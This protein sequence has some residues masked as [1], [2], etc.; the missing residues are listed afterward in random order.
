MDVLKELVQVLPPKKLQ[1]LQQLQT[2]SDEDS[3]V[4]R[5]YQ[6]IATGKIDTDEDARSFLQEISDSHFYK[7]KSELKG[8]LI[9]VLFLAELNEPGYVD[10]QKAY[11][12]VYKLW[13][14]IKLLLGKHAKKTAVQFARKLLT[15]AE[16]FEF[17]DLALDI[18]R[19]L[20]LHYGTIEGDEKKF[21]LYNDRFKYF[22]KL[23]HWEN[24]AEEYY[25]DLILQY[26]RS[27]KADEEV[28]DKAKGYLQELATGAADLDSYQL[29]LCR[30]LIRIMEYSGAND[31][32]KTIEAAKTLTDYFETKTYTAI[33][34][35]QIGYNQQLV[36]YILLK[37]FE[38]GK[39][40][41]DRGLS[42]ENRGGFNWFKFQEL[43]LLLALHAQEYGEAYQI[44][45]QTIKH[46]RFGRLPSATQEMWKIFEAY[47]AY[48]I[49]I[50]RVSGISDNALKNFR[51]GRFLNETPIFSRDKRGMNIPILVVQVLFFISRKDYSKA[52]DRIEA[53]KKYSS[54]YLRK[55]QSFRSN[56]FL[57][58][59]VEV[60]KANFHKAAVQRNT[61]DLLQKLAEVPVHTANQSYEIEILPFEDSWEMVLDSLDHDFH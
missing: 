31:Y 15:K 56:C 21:Q 45:Q 7:L 32:A 52:H 14:A 9:N 8:R 51:L 37:D 38:R 49:S 11:F 40:I 29:D 22:E 60:S 44:Y 50:D 16:Q 2:L 17:T 57:K 1:A 30:G 18:C 4:G 54:R 26:V 34:P 41:V 27:K 47:L 24:R 39:A 46:P 53:L 55:D 61:V 23:F 43:Y 48:L 36:G 35:L 20:R 5:F 13:A 12:E 6:A 10:R 58:M 3:L 19:T 33:T 59:L 42:L 25:A 28:V